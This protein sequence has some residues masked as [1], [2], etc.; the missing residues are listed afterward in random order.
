MICLL[1]RSVVGEILMEGL[2][3]FFV[4]TRPS[5]DVVSDEDE[6][7]IAELPFYILC[8]VFLTF[9][10]S[11]RKASSLPSSGAVQTYL[12]LRVFYRLHR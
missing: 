8:T 3:I 6:R 2:I 5:I 4:K 11:E 9:L 10:F 1:G 12:F 7:L